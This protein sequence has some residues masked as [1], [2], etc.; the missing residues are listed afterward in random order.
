[1]PT[2]PILK[3]IHIESAMLK[4]PAPQ[5]HVDIGNDKK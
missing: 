3:Y 5:I 4:E 2:G 1:M